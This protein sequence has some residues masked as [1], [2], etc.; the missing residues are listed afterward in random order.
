MLEIAFAEV[1]LVGN[2]SRPFLKLC[3]E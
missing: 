2:K 3:G 1:I